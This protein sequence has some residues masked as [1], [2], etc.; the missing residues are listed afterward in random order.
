MSVV[1]T[2]YRFLYVV[3][4]AQ[5]SANDASPCILHLVLPM[6]LRTL[7]THLICHQQGLSQVKTKMLFV[8]TR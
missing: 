4:H 8:V 2:H 6:P 5:D 1:D 3:I 7:P